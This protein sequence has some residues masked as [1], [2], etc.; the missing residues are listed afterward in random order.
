MNKR[1]VALGVFA[2]LAGAALIPATVGAAGG[3]GEVDA[4]AAI[5]GW[6]DALASHDA[7]T[8]AKVLAPEFQIMRS[9]GSGYDSTNYLANLPKFNGEPEIMELAFGA[10]GDLL[11]ARYNLKLEQKI[12]DKPVQSLAPRLSVFRKDAAGWLIVAHANFAQIG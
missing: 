11:V 8:V 12:G 1:Q 2:G 10:N 4:R 9:D 3:A 5:L 6:L 7:A